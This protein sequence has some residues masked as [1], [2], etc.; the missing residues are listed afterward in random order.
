MRP[1]ALTGYVLIIGLFIGGL[2]GCAAIFT[3]Q[4]Y[5][6]NLALMPGTEAN[7][8]A[9][10]DGD[11]KTAGETTFPPTEGT[12]EY[13]F[14][15]PPTEAYVLFPEPVTISKVVLYSDDLKGIDLLIE[16]PAQGWE[17]HNKYDGLK[18]PVITL[19]TK[20]LVRATGVKIRVRRAKGDT[21]LRRKNVRRGGGWTFVTGETRAPASI[22]E[23]EVYGPSSATAAEKD[24]PEDPDEV[25]SILLEDLGK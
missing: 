12:R 19:K 16:D 8:P 3:P 5:G 6:E 25:T 11:L 1:T 10:I 20:G 2:T 4:E 7:H 17:L 21:E 13:R 24:T 18:G 9:F 22:Y 15:S 14:G 23:I